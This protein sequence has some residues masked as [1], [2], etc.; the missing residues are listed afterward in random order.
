MPQASY[1]AVNEVAGPQCLGERL[2][3]HPPF[4]KSALRFFMCLLAFVLE[5]LEQSGQIRNIGIIILG[6]PEHD[7]AMF[8]L[9]K[10]APS[11]D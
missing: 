3:S 4:A 10:L 8:I 1:L 6:L 5:H 7:L 2:P 9:S 11:P